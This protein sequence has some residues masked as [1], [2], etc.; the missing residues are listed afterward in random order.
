ML[1]FLS[2]E[3]KDKGRTGKSLRIIGEVPRFIFQYNHC[4]YYSNREKHIYLV[5]KFMFLCVHMHRIK[6]LTSFGNFK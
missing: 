1:F 3:R 2:R 4:R 5:Q 6:P